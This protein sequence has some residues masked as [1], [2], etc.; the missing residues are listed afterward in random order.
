M[1]LTFKRL[2][3]IDF[4]NPQKPLQILHKKIEGVYYA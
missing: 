3:S 2:L 4:S 1:I